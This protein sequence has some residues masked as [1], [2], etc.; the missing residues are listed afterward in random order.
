M[1]KEQYDSF[2]TTAPP[3]GQVYENP[4]A[5]KF[6]PPRLSDD[7]ESEGKLE[8]RLKRIALGLVVFLTADWLQAALRNRGRSAAFVAAVVLAAFSAFEQYLVHRRGHDEDKDP[9]SP[10]THVTR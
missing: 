10:P 1:L 3:V 7:L 5:D 8:R 6:G 2:A 4:S 9:Y